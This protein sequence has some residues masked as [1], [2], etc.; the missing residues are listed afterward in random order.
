MLMNVGE[1]EVRKVKA[2]DDGFANEDDFELIMG[3]EFLSVMYVM[4]VFGE[5]VEYLFVVVLKKLGLFLGG[6]VS[7]SYLGTS[8][9]ETTYGSS[10]VLGATFVYMMM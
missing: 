3:K 6:V 1:M 10:N 5:S 9:R 8:G 4:I 7:V 2:R